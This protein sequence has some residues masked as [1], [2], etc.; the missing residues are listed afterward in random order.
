[1]PAGKGT[2]RGEGELQAQYLKN[3]PQHRE[4]LGTS[5]SGTQIK[6]SGDAF[7]LQSLLTASSS[8]R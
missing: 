6:L 4:G 5:S 2:R 7:C 8:R 1:M 3:K